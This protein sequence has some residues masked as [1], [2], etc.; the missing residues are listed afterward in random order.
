MSKRGF[1]A[2][3]LFCLAVLII[4]LS[5]PLMAQV[6][7]DVNGDNTVTIVDALLIAQYYVGLNPA[8]FNSAVADV[9]CDGS[10]TIVDALVIAQYYVGLVSSFPCAAT[11]TPIAATPAPTAVVTPGPTP[12]GSANSY[13]FSKQMGAGWNAGNT[14]EATGG[15]TAWGNPLLNQTIFNAVKAAGFKT[16]RL[17]VAWSQFSD[18]ANYVISSTWMARVTEVVN[19][20]LNAGLYVIVN[21]HWDGGWMN[22]PTY[23]QQASINNRLSIMWKQ[24]AT[25]FRDFDNRL[26]FA[27]TNEVMMANDYNTPTAEYYTVQNSFNQAF[28]NAVRATGGN[29][30]SRYLVVQGF[31]TNIDYTT[32]Y[33]VMP[34][35]TASNHLLV[36]VHYYDPYDFTLNT[37][38]N[39]TQWGAIATD[40]GKVESWAN[41]SHVDSQ[42]QKMKSNYIDKGI[43]VIMGEF[44]VGSRF[45]VS[46][47]D[48]YR[49][50]YDKYVTQSAVSHGMIPCYWDSGCPATDGSSGIFDRNNGNKAYPDIVNAIVSAAP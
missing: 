7:G 34:T 50:Y 2:G 13:E 44:G 8:S 49:V 12:L 36:E 14:M 43:G 19:M 9:N 37:T 33:F 31:N 6:Q 42:F 27:G 17:P 38:S 5:A 28:V 22:N 48:T 1:Q 23:A 26:L 10:I 45:T 29:N 39:I 16:V 4:C 25:N 41:E 24:I 35:D 11:P 20:A 47:F 18:S 21:E 46:G 30:A 3:R 40:S 32:S 15:E